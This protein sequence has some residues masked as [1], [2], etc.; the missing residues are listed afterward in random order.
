MPTFKEPPTDTPP[1]NLTGQQEGSA[2]KNILAV[3]ALIMAGVLLS[4][5]LGLVRNRV[6]AHQFGQGYETD[7]FNVAFTVP[8]VIYNVIAGG[9]IAA[10]IIPVFS[11]YIEQG[12]EKDAWRIF[13]IVAVWTFFVIGL[14]IILG[15]IFTVPLT[16][17]FFPKFPP[18]KVLETAR[19]TRILLPAQVLFF[20]GGL[21]MA[22]LQVKKNNMGQVWG[23]AIY[24][25]GIIAGGLFLAS[26]MGVSGLCWGAVGGAFVGNFL[27][28]WIL[29]RRVGGRFSPAAFIKYRGHPGAKQVWNLMWP[30]IFSLSLPQVSAV[31]TRFF[32]AAIKN[33]GTISALMNANQLMQVPLGVFAQALGLAIF[34]TLAMQA[35]Q[36]DRASLRQTVNFGIRFILFLNIPCAVLMII[37]SLPIVQLLLET[38]KFKG[39]DSIETAL[40]LSCFTVGLFAWSVQAIVARGFYSLKDSR[41]PAIIGTLV[42]LIFLAANWFMVHHI[43]TAHYTRA[44]SVLALINSLAAILNTGI[45]LLLLRRK[46]GGIEA[47]KLMLGVVKIVVASALMGLVSWLIYQMI[48]HG[49][50]LDYQ[51][52]VVSVGKEAADSYEHSSAASHA[53]RTLI[54]SVGSGVLVYAIMA[55][56]LRMD[57]AKLFVDLISKRLQRK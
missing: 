32:A 30:I 52:L 11:E 46:L 18:Q 17:Q 28:Q 3:T 23:P 44:G 56:V 51:H 45:L 12:K 22:V 53:A 57:E 34:P 49:Y 13:S 48:Q 19:L 36:K 2:K 50:T 24:N 38:G 25:L 10:S 55:F 15:E 20:L 35:A 5:L 33:D 8:D 47:G 14:L 27:L 54:A 29:I 21:M 40:Y 41:T 26:K 9:A 42:T 31:A 39:T 7:I 37:L 43:D 16:H 6:I 4:R 1:E